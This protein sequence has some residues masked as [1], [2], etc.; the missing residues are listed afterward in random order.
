MG[1]TCFICGGTDAF[2]MHGVQLCVWGL[3]ICMCG[4]GVWCGKLCVVCLKFILLFNEGL[5]VLADMLADTTKE[6]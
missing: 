6:M 1:K 2:L 4:V 5:T 3:Y